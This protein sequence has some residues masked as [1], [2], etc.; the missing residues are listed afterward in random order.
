[1]D[2]ENGYHVELKIPFDELNQFLPAENDQLGLDFSVV[3]VDDGTGQKEIGWNSAISLRD[4][5]RLMGVGFLGTESG[6][7]DP[8][9]PCIYLP[10][11]HSTP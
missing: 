5:A 7:A 3:D 2:T 6:C 8:H 10:L 1:M 11:I 9:T 4:D